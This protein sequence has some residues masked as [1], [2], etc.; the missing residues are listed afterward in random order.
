MAQLT[1]SRSITAAAELSGNLWVFL[2]L[3]ESA[4]FGW[5][6][7]K[8]GSGKRRAGEDT[9]PYGI[10]RATSRFAVGA[11]PRPARRVKRIR[12]EGHTPG[13]LLLPLRGNS[14]SAPPLQHYS[15]TRNGLVVFVGEPL[16]LPPHPSGLTASHLPLKGK[17]LKTRSSA[18]PFRG[19]CPRRGRMRY[20]CFELGMLARQTQAREWNRASSNFRK[21]RA[22]W[23]GGNLECHSDFARRKF[24]L[25]FQACVPRNGGPGVRRI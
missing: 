21:P 15:T 22:Q 13:W 23:P 10:R 7:L 18:F 14:P 11:G 4:P 20:P 19:R 24:R 2:L 16:G 8:F 3:V 9:R 17:A 12:R 25:H 1:G 5:V 6:G